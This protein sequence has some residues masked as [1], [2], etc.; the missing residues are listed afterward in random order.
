MFLTSCWRGFP[1]S[2][3]GRHRKH[4]FAVAGAVAR[5]HGLPAEIVRDSRHE[6]LLRLDGQYRTVHGGKIMPASKRQLSDSCDQSKFPGPAAIR[7]NSRASM[8]LG[9][10]LAVLLESRRRGA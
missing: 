1:A 10:G 3:L 8:P 4:E 9:P 6:E 7:A 5:K 2:A